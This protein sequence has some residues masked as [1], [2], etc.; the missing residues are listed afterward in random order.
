MQPFAIRGNGCL[1]DE[2][3]VTHVGCWGWCAPQVRCFREFDVIE[4]QQTFCEPPRSTTL[5]KAWAL[6]NTMFMGDDARR[7]RRLLAQVA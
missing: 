6:C 1:G 5:A 2:Q 4:G 7:C 3:H